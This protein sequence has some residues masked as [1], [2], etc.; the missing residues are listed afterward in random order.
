MNQYTTKIW[1]ENPDH[2]SM[3]QFE[4][5]NGSSIYYGPDRNEWFGFD[6]HHEEISLPKVYD[7]VSRHNLLKEVEVMS[8][9]CTSEVSKNQQRTIKRGLTNNGLLQLLRIAAWRFS[10]S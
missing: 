4:F 2:V 3:I 5:L 10:R 6:K 8:L 9:E 1:K 7:I